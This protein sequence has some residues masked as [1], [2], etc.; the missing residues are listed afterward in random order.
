VNTSR[1]KP[2]IAYE[3]NRE[4]Y[5]GCREGYSG[6]R[7]GYSG[8]A[9][10]ATHNQSSRLWRAFFQIVENQGKITIKA[11]KGRGGARGGP[12]PWSRS[13]SESPTQTI[14]SSPC[15]KTG[16]SSGPPKWKCLLAPALL[17]GNYGR[18]KDFLSQDSKL[19]HL[20]LLDLADF[21]IYHYGFPFRFL[22]WPWVCASTAAYLCL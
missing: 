8:R 9:R 5:S 22:M 12:C 21:F 6:C 4:G 10:Y 1:P 20:N 13:L 18:L 14:D 16:P 19:S 11:F 15:C 3:K 7:E 2:Q 17:E